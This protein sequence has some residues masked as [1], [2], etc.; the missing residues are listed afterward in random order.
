MGITEACPWAHSSPETPP[1][2][3]HLCCPCGREGA[4]HEWSNAV[5]V[6]NSFTKTERTVGV[7]VIATWQMIAT[8]PG[9]GLLRLWMPPIWWKVMRH[10]F[11]YKN[12]VKKCPR[13]ELEMTWI[14]SKTSMSAF[15]ALLTKSVNEMS[16]DLFPTLKYCCICRFGWYL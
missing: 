4:S 7:K 11:V 13:Y 8:S 1:V 2:I 9:F 3:F 14:T 6:Q 16:G 10:I 5:I 12:A 15:N